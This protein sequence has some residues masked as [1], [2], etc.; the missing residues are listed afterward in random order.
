M[1]S[2]YSKHHMRPS[3]LHQRPSYTSSPRPDQY[4]TGHSKPSH[5][6]LHKRSSTSAVPSA[7]PDLAAI[8]PLPMDLPHEEPRRSL[9]LATH[10]ARKFKPYLRRLSTKERNSLDLSLPAA[11][12]ESFS[13]LGIQEYAVVPRSVPDANFPHA[14]PR[15][16]H[17]RSTSSNSQDSASS[18]RLRQPTVPY[19]NAIRQA[20]RQFKPPS[21][22]SHP[23]SVYEEDYIG[24][25]GDIMSSDEFFCRQPAL[26]SRR[27]S[28]SMSS[29]RNAPAPLHSL[30]TGSVTRLGSQSQT[31]LSNLRS[32]R[33]IS[34]SETAPSPGSRTSLDKAFGFVRGRESPV[35]PLSRAASIRAARMEFQAKE[36]AKE[37]KAEKEAMKKRD[38][39]ERRRAKQEERQQHISDQEEDY[40][41]HSLDEKTDSVPSADEEHPSPSP[42]E[43]SSPTHTVPPSTTR[44]VR[45]CTD[46]RTRRPVKSRWA[47]F[48]AWFRTRLLRLKCL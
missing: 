11:D 26:E 1:S 18:G 40:E 25:A 5:A 46:L 41:R 45:T 4:A 3:S 43:D 17:H 34:R 7:S 44:T 37:R 33:E 14:G 19:V 28:G 29:T 6:K 21:E 38:R 8:S 36:E 31:S 10:S 47:A 15:H 39:E 23:D 20:S 2:S 32:R 27:R 9:D 30:S 22:R 16:Q 48:V 35:D 13:A 12:N 42:T 24:E